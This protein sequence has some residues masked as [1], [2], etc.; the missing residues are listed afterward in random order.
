MKVGIIG[1][2]RGCVKTELLNHVPGA[3]VVDLT[4]QS[5][6]VRYTSFVHVVRYV[7]HGKDREEVGSR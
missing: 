3:T 7:V 5:C 2:A 4:R 1:S 6:Q